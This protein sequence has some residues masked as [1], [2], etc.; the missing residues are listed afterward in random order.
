[1]AEREQEYYRSGEVLITNR[2]AELGGQTF[3]IAKITAV[4]MATMSSLRA[5]CVL[6]LV[7]GAGFLVL[8]G[9]LTIETEG[10]AFLF[11]LG[12]LIAT[13]DMIWW[14]G[15]KLSYSVNI[16]SASGESKAMQS[17]NKEEIE[18]IVAAIKQAI[19]ERG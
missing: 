4:S 9:I 12:L 10:G 3:A 1:M 7:P 15:M 8:I 17:H 2:R 11:L 16:S 14:I 19:S 18:H 5:N 13:P 6:G